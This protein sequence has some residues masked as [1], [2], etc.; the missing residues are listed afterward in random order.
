M[1]YLIDTCVISEMIKPQPEVLVLSWWDSCVKNQI[2]ISSLSIGELYFGI[3]RLPDGKRKND[4]LPWFNQIIMAFSDRILPFS[5]KTGIIWAELKIFAQR[6]G[7]Q[8][9][10]I[11]G[12]LAATAKEHDLTFV[13]R[14]T[15]DVD[16]TGIMIHNPWVE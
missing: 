11:D 9:P 2:F 10:V 3:T 16:I 12:L 5:E 8:L 13:T 15:R 1:N 4:L 7:V 6:K 14:N